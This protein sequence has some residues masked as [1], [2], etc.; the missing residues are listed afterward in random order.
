MLVTLT[1]DDA[2]YGVLTPT[3]EANAF[4]FLTATLDP[5]FVSVH[6]VVL[7]SCQNIPTVYQITSEYTLALNVTYVDGSGPP[8]AVVES[9]VNGVGCGPCEAGRG[10]VGAR[11]CACG[12]VG[13]ETRCDWLC[14]IEPTGCPHMQPRSP[15]R[16]PANP[17]MRERRALLLPRPWRRVVAPERAHSQCARQLNSSALCFHIQP[18]HN[19]HVNVHRHRLAIRCRVPYRGPARDPGVQAEDV[20]RGAGGRHRPGQRAFHGVRSAGH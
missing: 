9:Q 10:D 14:V 6:K 7:Q 20:G 1:S 12:A 19:V 17:S 13:A 11:P 16:N 8:L 18:A 5:E 4:N 3:M 15:R 2:C